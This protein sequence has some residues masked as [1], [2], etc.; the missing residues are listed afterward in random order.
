MTASQVVFDP[1]SK[2]F[3]EDPYGVYRR[4][5][6]EAPVYYNEQYDF[7][8]LTRHE[9][10]SAAIKDYESFSSARGLDLATIKNGLPPEMRSILTMDPP[11]HRRLR[12]LV[13]KAFTPRAVG[14]LKEMATEVIEGRL[15]AVNPD[16]FDVVQDFSAH[17]PIEVIARMLGV[18]E[19]QCHT[20]RDCVDTIIAREPGEMAM[21]EAGWAALAEMGT[22]YFNLIQERRANPQDDMISALIAA[23]IDREDGTTSRL[24]DVEIAGFSMVLGGAGSETTTRLIGSAAVLFARNPDQWEKLLADRTKIAAAVEEVLRYEAPTTYLV[25]YSL[26]D[27][28][29]SGGTIPAGKPVFIIVGAADRDPEAFT[30][31]D[32]FDIDRDRNEAQNLGFGL[33]IHS[34]IGAALARMESAI[35]LGKLLD[36]MPRYEVIWD[37]C[38]RVSMQNVVGWKNVPVRVLR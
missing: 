23:E 36:F 12:S 2:E 22:L 32:V 13:N 27:M 15:S 21:G 31:P 4:M 9:D 26:K 20:V 33:G 29:F 3:F 1:F 6:E 5:R 37:R 34:C 10:V 30:D 7:Y 19:E 14:N 8:A 25:R 35:A 28:H 16:Q 11:E 24:D 18:P 17:F 38:E